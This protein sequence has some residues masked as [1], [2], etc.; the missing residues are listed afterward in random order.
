MRIVLLPVFIPNF[1]MCQDNIYQLKRYIRSKWKNFMDE[2]LNQAVMVRSKFCNI[3][4]KLKIEEN[5]LAYIV[6]RNHCIKLLRQKT[7]VL[8]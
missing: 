3:F 7:A 6:R 2:E 5:K 8:K 4:V 1:F